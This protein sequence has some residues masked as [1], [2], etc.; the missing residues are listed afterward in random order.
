MRV[1]TFVKLVCALVVATIVALSVYF[2]MHVMGKPVPAPLARLFLQWMPEP[3]RLLADPANEHEKALDLP[4]MVDIEPGD[5]AFQKAAELLATG[6]IAE[7]REKLLFLINYY[8]TSNAAP[9]ARQILGEMNLDDFLS[10]HNNPH[11]V[12][13]QVKR[14]DSY[15]GITAKSQTTLD[16]LM[17]FNALLEM[18]PLQPSDE[19]NIMPLNL[20]VVIEPKR[21]T[22]SLWN[23]GTFLKEYRMIKTISLPTTTTTLKIIN[24]N[25]MLGERSVAAGM[26]GYL[27]SQKVITLDRKLLIVA[28]GNSTVPGCHLQ[29]ADTE[30]LALLLRVG[31]EVEIRP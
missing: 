19:L 6:K 16:A 1:W 9:M 23:G 25:G 2:T 17:H 30:E 10:L 29:P 3:E 14:G 31:N 28:A 20:R 21:E 13:Y 26:K 22:L 8:P 27:E 7:A 15:L 18:R 12:T 11:L 5:K 24:K 4:E